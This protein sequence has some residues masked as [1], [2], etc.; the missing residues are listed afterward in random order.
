MRQVN[1]QVLSGSDA[2]TVY[3]SQL[4]TNQIINSSFHCVISDNT[5]AGTFTVQASNDIC[6]VGQG[7]QNFVVTN[8]VNIPSATVTLTAGQKQ[9]IIFV[10]E[11]AYRWMRAVYT[12]TTPGTGTV[13]V[14]WFAQS[15]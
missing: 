1:T 10:S 14:N 7:D 3:G 6:A 4:D 15:V 12:S 2:A 8:W 11:S 13:V 9:G 5:A